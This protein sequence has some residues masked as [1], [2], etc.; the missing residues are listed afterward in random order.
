MAAEDPHVPQLADWFL[1]RWEY[2]VVV[3][4]LL[5]VVRFT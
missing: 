5:V 3:C 1:R 4:F 2:G